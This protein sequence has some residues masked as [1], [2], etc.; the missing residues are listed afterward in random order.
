MIPFVQSSLVSREETISRT[1]L[2]QHHACKPIIQVPEVHTTHATLIIPI[3]PQLTNGQLSCSTPPSPH[4]YP[5]SHLSLLPPA[6]SFRSLHL[7]ENHKCNKTQLR[8][9]NYS[10]L[11]IYINSLAHPDLKRPYPLAGLCPSH[12]LA[13]GRARSTTF[14]LE[15]GLELVAPRATPAITV[16]VVIAQQIVAAR[17]GAAAHLERLIYGREQVFGQMRGEG[18]QPI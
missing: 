5:V 6:Y 11:P 17:T 13:C 10:Q 9:K 15:R 2:Q 8:R 1:L 7:E 4:T 14:I 3:S 16:A 18:A 12:I